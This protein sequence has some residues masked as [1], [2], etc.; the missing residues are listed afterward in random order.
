MARSAFISFSVFGASNEILAVVVDILHVNR[1]KKEDVWPWKHVV[2][3]KCKLW[4]KPRT[5]CVN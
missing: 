2:A 3:E 5:F 4:H 1:I